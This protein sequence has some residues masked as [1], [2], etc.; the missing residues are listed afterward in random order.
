MDSHYNNLNRKLDKLQNKQQPKRK[1][2]HNQFHPRTINLTNIKLTQEEISL[3]N[4]GLQHSIENPMEKYW[5]ELIMDTELAIR[6]LE[7]KMQAP[8]RILAS[9]KLNQ[10]KASNNH[11]SIEAKRQS[12]VLK[13][14]K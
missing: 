5:T 9:R 14:P 8:Y 10:I 13:K 7:P 3:L 1:A 6:K 4:N 11:Y 2:E 12:Y